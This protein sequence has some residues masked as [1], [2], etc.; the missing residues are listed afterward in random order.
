MTKTTTATTTP[1]TTGR[2]LARRANS[3]TIAADNPRGGGGRRTNDPAGL[4]LGRSSKIRRIL[5]RRRRSRPSLRN[6]MVQKGD[7]VAQC[8]GY[9]LHHTL[10]SLAR[11]LEEQ[12]PAK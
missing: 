11:G 5:H 1:P 12:G 6:G 7:D 2:R 10:T 8:N 3:T 9:A 4:M